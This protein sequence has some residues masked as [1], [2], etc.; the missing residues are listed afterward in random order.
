MSSYK[1]PAYTDKS[2]SSFVVISTFKQI[3]SDRYIESKI[4][5]DL[6]DVG[7]NAIC[8]LDLLPP[9]RD[10]SV[11]ETL[12]IIQATG[13]DA[14]LTVQLT[15]SYSRYHTST[16]SYHTAGTVS[17]Y[18]NTSYVNA[19][20]TQMGGVTT[21]KPVAEFRITVIDVETGARVL[22]ADSTTRGNAYARKNDLFASLAQEI[23]DELIK[24]KTIVPFSK[25]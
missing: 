18:G 12:S 11:E 9:T 10:Y 3:D 4:S 13:A 15:D 24:S 20:T 2:Y 8:G 6:E 19:N 22:I 14:I 5:E 21:S 23:V 17:T 25:Q 1:D 7:V 16:P